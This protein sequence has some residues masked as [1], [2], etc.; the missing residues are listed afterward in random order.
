M[1][2]WHFVPGYPDYEINLSTHDVRHK[3]TRQLRNVIV[4]DGYKRVSLKNKK[5]QCP[6]K[7]AT[8]L[9]NILFGPLGD[10][11]VIRHLNDDRTDDRL[12][13]LAVGTPCDNV[14]DAIRNGKGPGQSHKNCHHPRTAKARLHCNRQRRG[15]I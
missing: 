1:S 11:V 3:Q 15:I 2:E 14:E 7:I 9:G 5:D 12:C 10:G 4:S 6:V 13:N 8:I